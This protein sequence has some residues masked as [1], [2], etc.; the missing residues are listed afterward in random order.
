MPALVIKLLNYCFFFLLGNMSLS[1]LPFC[2]GLC[3]SPCAGGGTITAGLNDRSWP[4]IGHVA[5]TMRRAVVPLTSLEVVQPPQHAL[6]LCDWLEQDSKVFMIGCHK[7]AEPAVSLAA[8]NARLTEHESQSLRGS[9]AQQQL[10]HDGID[11]LWYFGA[12]LN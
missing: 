8:A 11:L 2:V 10:D 3:N 9:R 7:S 6:E 5:K 12:C 1:W 4:Y